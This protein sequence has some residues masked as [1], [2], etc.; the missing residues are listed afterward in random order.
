MLREMGGVRTWGRGANVGVLSKQ[1]MALQRFKGGAT[2][3][4]KAKKG[5]LLNVHCTR[6]LSQ[7]LPTLSPTLHLSPHFPAGARRRRS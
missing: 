5:P 4:E 2:G 3:R 6:P 1:G 7:C